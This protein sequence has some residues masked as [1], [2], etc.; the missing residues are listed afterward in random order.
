MLP[1]C[2]HVCVACVRVRPVGAV[3]GGEE[4]GG[5]DRHVPPVP[6]VPPVAARPA[7]LARHCH[8]QGTIEHANVDRFTNTDI[9]RA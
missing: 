7:P 5:A 4:E 8:P 6:P 1:L 3:M 2:V 9:F